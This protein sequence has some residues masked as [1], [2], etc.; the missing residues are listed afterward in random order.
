MGAASLAE[1]PGTVKQAA[2]TWSSEPS[3]KQETPYSVNGA[4][5]RK[6]VTTDNIGG[7][8]AKRHLCQKNKSGVRNY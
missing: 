6:V 1:P 8:L 4:C 3:Q 7:C 5:A 2:G